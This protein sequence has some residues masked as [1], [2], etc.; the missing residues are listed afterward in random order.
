MKFEE[1]WPRGYRESFKGVDGWMAS[2]TI[3]YPEPYSGELKN[4]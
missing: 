1:N 2:V 3:A 4:E